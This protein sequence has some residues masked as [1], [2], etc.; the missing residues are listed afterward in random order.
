MKVKQY[1]FRK[2]F[3]LDMIDQFLQEEE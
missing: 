1:L 2:G 3:S